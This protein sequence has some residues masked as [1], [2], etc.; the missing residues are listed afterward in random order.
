[1]SR[2]MGNPHAG[3][4]SLSSLFAASCAF[5]ADASSCSS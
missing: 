2:I 5:G 3:Q 4:G 1:V